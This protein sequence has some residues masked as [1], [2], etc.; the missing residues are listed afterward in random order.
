MLDT[1]LPS[2]AALLAAAAAL[3]L[4]AVNELIMPSTVVKGSFSAKR[5]GSSCKRLQ[6]NA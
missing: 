2:L 6:H 1:L 5:T 3:R 4:S